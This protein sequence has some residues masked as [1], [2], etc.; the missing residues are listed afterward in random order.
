[1]Y[2]VDLL[3]TVTECYGTLEENSNF[4]VVCVNEDDDGRA[5]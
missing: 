5:E 2:K 4:E 1:M 3:G